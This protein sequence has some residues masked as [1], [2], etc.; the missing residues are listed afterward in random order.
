MALVPGVEVE[1]DDWEVTYTRGNWH[2]YETS[3]ASLGGGVDIDGVTV[4]AR[5]NMDEPEIKFGVIV[6]AGAPGR[7]YYPTK[8]LSQITFGEALA[9]VE[10]E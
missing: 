2:D 8:E 10:K 1:A 9:A 6:P 3:P 7:R 4:T 5:K